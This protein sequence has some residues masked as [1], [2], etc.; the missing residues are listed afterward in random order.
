MNGTL[1][2]FKAQQDKATQI[3]TRLQEFVEQGEEYGLSIDEG[4]K[5]KLTNALK[6]VQDGKLKVVLVGGFSEGKT[7]IAAAW[8][9]KL[10][11]A[12]MKISHE[13]SSDEVKIYNVDDEIELVDTP[14]LFG[15]K[16][17]FSDETHT[18]Q[19][20][21]DITKRYVSE[22]HLVLYVL[23]SVNPI[24]QKATKAI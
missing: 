14:G 17:K 20:Y 3:L 1:K 7:S 12:S 11:K 24:K 8:L 18:I 9:E 19:K 10:D 22:A 4:V 15:F 13:E 2:E 23:N 21:K 5:T 16:E 6:S